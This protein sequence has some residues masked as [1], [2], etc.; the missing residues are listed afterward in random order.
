MG[1]F[2]VYMRIVRGKSPSHV[3]MALHKCVEANSRL[4]GESFT[5]IFTRLEKIYGFEREN[6]KHW[7]T[8]NKMQRAGDLL[9]KERKIWLEEMNSLIKIRKMQK[10]KGKRYKRYERLDEMCTK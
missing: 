4:T 8:V 3:W 1:Q 2:N 5:S 10:K 7:P 9:E 6:K